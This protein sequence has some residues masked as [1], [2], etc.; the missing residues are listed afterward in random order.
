MEDGLTVAV[1]AGHC[2]E[3]RPL[4]KKNPKPSEAEKLLPALLSAFVQSG[5]IGLTIGNNFSI[6]FSYL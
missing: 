3:Y 1:H 2:L 5:T 6:N 4:N